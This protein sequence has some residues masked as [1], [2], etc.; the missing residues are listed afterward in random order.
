MDNEIVGM[1]KC[2][3]KDLLDRKE[4]FICEWCLFFRE[5]TLECSM[6]CSMLKAIRK[7]LCEDYLMN[8]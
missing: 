8:N 7:D 5:R 2:V 6:G 3:V 1:D 4:P